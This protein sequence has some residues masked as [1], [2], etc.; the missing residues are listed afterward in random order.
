VATIEMPNGIGLSPAPTDEKKNRT[1]YVSDTIFGRLWAFEVTGPG[2]VGKW[3]IPHVMQGMVV[4][5]LPAVGGVF[6]WLDSLK[7][8]ECGKICVATLF[9]GG[10]TVFSPDGTTEHVPTGDMV[11][12]NLCF[13]GDD[14]RDVWITASGTG[15]ILK[16]RWPRPGLALAHD[17]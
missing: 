17:A 3:V 4:Q 11:T 10:I 15:K 7:V 1:L 14:M 8:E 9:N 12:T 16:G 5:T 13:G 6:Q 2:E